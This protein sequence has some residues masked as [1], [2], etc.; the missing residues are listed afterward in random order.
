MP[1]P[2]AS[3][4]VAGPATAYVAPVGTPTPPVTGSSEWPI[5]WTGAWLPFGYTD[6]GVT[7]TYTPTVKPYTPDEETSPVY[8]I[9]TAEK[10]EIDITLAEV[11]LANLNYAIAASALSTDAV[12]GV[13]KVTAGNGTA[14]GYVSLGIQGPAPVGTN[15]G[16]AKGRMLIVQKALVTSA[17][18]YDISRKSVA[19]FAAKFEARKIA[20]QDLFDLYEFTNAAS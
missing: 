9:L 3:N 12:T 15:V 13:N 4:I 6:K 11:T 1:E 8:D 18:K 10:F 5:S 17:I 19:L 16:P 7:L 2:T 20:G 14:L